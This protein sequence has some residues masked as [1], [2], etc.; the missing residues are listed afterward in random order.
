[1]IGKVG[2]IVNNKGQAL[3]EF[4]LLLPII[5]FIIFGIIDFGII[6]NEKNTLENNSLDIINLYNNGEK[7]ENIK[8]IY[9]DKNIKIEELENYY[10]ISITKNINLITPGL[11]RIFGSPYQI[12]TE[13]VVPY[14]K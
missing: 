11:D 6:F 5:I 9:K 13:R 12:K 2:G 14:A 1:M 3:I 7:I 8:G 10:K 4:V